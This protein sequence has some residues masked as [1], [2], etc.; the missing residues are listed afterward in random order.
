LIIYEQ[1]LPG[2]CFIAGFLEGLRFSYALTILFAGGCLKRKM[3]A[4][5]LIC[6]FLSIPISSLHREADDR[7]QIN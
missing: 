5:N 4:N 1:T 6:N 2:Q 3:L 7:E